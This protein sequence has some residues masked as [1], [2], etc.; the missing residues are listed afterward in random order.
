MYLYS[1][2]YETKVKVHYIQGYFPSALWLMGS[3]YSISEGNTKYMNQLNM[4]L[5]SCEVIHSI[6]TMQTFIV[7]NVKENEVPIKKQ[8]C[9][10]NVVSEIEK[11]SLKTRNLEKLKTSIFLT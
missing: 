2:N 6:R 3:E 7:Q 11:K 1:C 9:S 5:I 10:I 4:Q 8:F